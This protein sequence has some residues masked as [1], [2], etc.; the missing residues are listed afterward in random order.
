MSEVEKFIPTHGP[1]PTARWTFDVDARDVV[2][3]FHGKIYGNPKFA[4]GKMYMVPGD[5]VVA[6]LPFN[7]GERTL[8]IWSYLPTTV[9]TE[10]NFISIKYVDEKGQ[11]I[12]VGQWDGIRFGGTTGKLYPGSS[13]NHRSKV[14]DIPL[15][16]SPPDEPLHLAAVY[17]RDSTITLYRNG[18]I[19]GQSF[20]PEHRSADNDLVTYRKGEAAIVIGGNM[21]FVVDEARLYTR[22]LSAAEIATSYRTFKK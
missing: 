3:N 4:E 7:V 18:K 6:W 14:L 5:R 11:G 1:Q 9:H 15:E 20:R 22:A 13:F 16:T 8:E 10:Q 17:A 21:T 12:G 2:G 19:L